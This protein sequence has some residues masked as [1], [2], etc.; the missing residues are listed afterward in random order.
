MQDQST[1]I[2]YPFLFILRIMLGKSSFKN[3]MVPLIRSEQL[4]FDIEVGN[5]IV[6]FPE[7][8]MLSILGNKLPGFGV[9]FLFKTTTDSVMSYE[10]Y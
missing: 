2:S 7:L 4:V 9:Q 8:S 3:F 10:I 6:T 1:S 5:K